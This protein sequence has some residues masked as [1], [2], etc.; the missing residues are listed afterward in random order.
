MNAVSD[1]IRPSVILT[2]IDHVT[3][4]ELARAADGSGPSPAR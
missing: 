2:R 1:L 4:L 3:E